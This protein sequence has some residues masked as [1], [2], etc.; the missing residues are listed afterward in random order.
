LKIWSSSDV[1]E[2][3]GRA[4]RGWQ[5]MSSVHWQKE[6]RGM[7]SG[8]TR[9]SHRANV[10]PVSE[11]EDTHEERMVALQRAVLEVAE[12]SEGA[13]VGV[14]MEHLAA[15]I[16]AR[17]L[18]VPP[19]GWLEAVAHD[20]VGGRTYVVSAAALHE[21]GVALPAMDEIQ[22]GQL[23]GDANGDRPRRGDQ[24]N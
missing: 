16:T 5:E 17:G 20:A 11:H 2:L 4:C 15:A 23:T 22:S 18:A 13:S 21:V 8:R 12:T 1:C 10:S 14:T 9:G 3:V 6:E 19:T 24:A 7:A